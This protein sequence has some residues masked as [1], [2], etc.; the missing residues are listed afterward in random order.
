[1]PSNHHNTSLEP[2]RGVTS[3]KDAGLA[4]GT[5]P[6][7]RPILIALGVAAAIGLPSSL[8]IGGPSSPGIGK[9]APQLD[10]V[11]VDEPSRLDPSRLEPLQGF[12][13]GSIA[14]LHFWGTWC[15]PCR[16]EFPELAAMV[17]QHD[18]SSSFVF[19]PV[20]CEAHGGE[21]FASLLANTEHYYDSQQLVLPCLADPRGVTRRSVAQRL[22]ADTMLYPTSL[23]IDGDGRIAGVWEGYAPSSVKQMKTLI[24]HLLKST[25]SRSEQGSKERKASF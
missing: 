5:L 8:H 11:F 7:T 16:M 13:E 1:M 14:L 17:G 9:P 23:V 18:A 15:G 6:W 21:T 2:H 25:K 12:P 4:R 10:L 3:D 19:L 22:E 20:S 24:D